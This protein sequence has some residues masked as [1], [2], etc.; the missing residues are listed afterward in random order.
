MTITQITFLCR[1]YTDVTIFNKKSIYLSCSQRIFFW[2]SQ[3]KNKINITKFSLYDNGDTRPVKLTHPI[4]KNGIFFQQKVY[5]R[6]LSA[7]T[8]G[9]TV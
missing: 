2:Y 3:T 8:V 1:K 4:K 9:G 6:D 7:I 5:L